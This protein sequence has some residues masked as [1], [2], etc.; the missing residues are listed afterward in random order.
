MKEYIEG[1]KMNITVRNFPLKTE[2]LQKS[3]KLKTVEMCIRFL[4]PI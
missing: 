1:K 4:Q 2:E 3:G